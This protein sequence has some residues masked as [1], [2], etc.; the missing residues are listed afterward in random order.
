MSPGSPRRGSRSLPPALTR[1]SV[2]PVGGG[3]ST[4]GSA[5]RGRATAAA[6]RWRMGRRRH[7]RP[8][9]RLP[10]ARRSQARSACRRRHDGAQ[11]GGGHV[12]PADRRR[13][14]CPGRPLLVLVTMRDL[15]AQGTRRR[16]PKA[17][18]AAPRP[19]PRLTHQ[20][21]QR[22]RSRLRG[23]GRGALQASHRGLGQAAAGRH[24]H[25]KSGKAFA[26]ARR[27]GHPRGPALCFVVTRGTDC[28]AYGVAGRPAVSS[29]CR[30]AHDGT[31]PG[32]GRRSLRPWPDRAS[33]LTVLGKSAYHPRGSD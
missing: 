9:A 25:L 27:V 24:G 26:G 18:R 3:S 4:A 1:I 15:D 32:S 33:G 11:D 17:G 16:V 31:D 19:R 2:G 23:A 5:V 7:T 13:V 20:R 22:G 28:V 29:R 10:T 14:V 21:H 12:G 6:C 30:R 8:V